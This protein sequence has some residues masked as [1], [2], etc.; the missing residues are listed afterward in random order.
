[1]FFGKTAACATCHAVGGQ[2]AS[3]GPD[4]TKI[5]SIRAGRDLLESVVFP[6]NSFARGY[7]SFV[8]QTKAN[9][10][11]AGVLAG[12]TPDAIVLRTPAEVRIPRSG[13]KSMRQDRVSIMPQGLDA[14]LSREELADLL[15]FL[16][17][18]K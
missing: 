2:G 6:S 4:L 17:S 14:Q 7:E 3:V 13:V 12:E 9:Q 15:A 10:L 16:Q 18:L 1:M 8:V 5:A 11:H